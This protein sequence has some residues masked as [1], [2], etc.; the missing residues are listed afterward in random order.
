MAF[1]AST[2]S[3]T[4]DRSKASPEKENEIN[5]KLFTERYSRTIHNTSTQVSF[6]VYSDC[7]K[8]YTQMAVR[9]S[10][11]VV[12][13]GGGGEVRGGQNPWLGAA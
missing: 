8:A 6:S 1:F 2:K 12:V 5:K 13:K 3:K 7:V 9:K 11:F 10:E 4:S